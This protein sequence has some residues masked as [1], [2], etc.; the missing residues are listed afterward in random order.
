MH[1]MKLLTGNHAI[2][3]MVLQLVRVETD[4]LLKVSK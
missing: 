2:L 1:A 3:L 4:Q